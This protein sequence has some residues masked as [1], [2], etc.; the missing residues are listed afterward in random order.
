MCAFDLLATV[1]GNLLLEK[2]S[3]PTSSNTSSQQDKCIIDNQDGQN[4]NKALKVELCDQGSCD[5][6]LFVSENA[7]QAHNV[8]HSSKESSFPQNDDDHS[9]FTSI[10]TTSNCSER[11]VAK[12]SDN[13]KLKNEVGSF[14]SQ[15]EEGLSMYR[16]SGGCKLEGEAKTLVKD[17]SNNTGRV[18]IGTVAD[19]CSSEYPAIFKGKPP[20]LPSSDSS[21]KAPLCG[22]QVPQR[23]LPSHR[24]DVKLVS[25]DDD[26]NSSGCTHPS[27]T[28]RYFKRAPR[29]GDRRI[30]KILASKY[31]KVG[32]KFKDGTLSNSG[33]WLPNIVKASV[34]HKFLVMFHRNCF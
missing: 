18:L 23:S 34:F 28:T 32:S 21:K 22:D 5:R 14:C 11:L 30:R 27:T 4:G 19:M 8:N 16:E 33:M 26:E 2:E 20:A 6:K 13:G 17:E 7:S 12:N 25:R 24:D 15:I 1:A 10:M 31:W 3:S 29:I 9:G